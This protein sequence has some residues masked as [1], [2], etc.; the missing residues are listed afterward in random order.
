MDEARMNSLVNS[1]S[2][3]GGTIQE[4][5]RS[6]RVTTLRNEQMQGEYTAKGTR[7]SNLHNA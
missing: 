4:K 7:L 3:G 1:K 6:R 2:N 5:K